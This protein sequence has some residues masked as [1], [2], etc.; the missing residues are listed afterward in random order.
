MAAGSERAVNAG[1]ASPSLPAAANFPGR[2]GRHPDS[3]C[4][5]A[6]LDSVPPDVGLLDRLGPARAVREGLLPWR[7]AGAVT[8]V[9]ATSPGA[10]EAGRARLEA[11][12]GPVALAS[13]TS[14]AVEAAVLAVRRGQLSARAEDRTPVRL[15]CRSLG[16]P[17][18]AV[19][20]TAAG[21]AVLAAAA[22]APALVFS[23]LV[24]W[25]SGWLLVSTLLRIAAAFAAGRTEPRRPP[26][27]PGRLPAISLL[28]PLFRERDIAG[29]LVAHLSRHDHP[30]SARSYRPAGDNAH[31]RRASR[32][33]ADEAPRAQLRPR[34]HAW[35]D[36][37]GL[38][39]RGLSGPRP[40]H[41]GRRPF[42]RRKARR[43]LPAR[44]ARLLQPAPELARALLHHRLRDVVRCHPARARPHGACRAPRR[45][46]A[47]F[48]PRRARPAGRVGRSQRHRGRRSRH[49]PRP[50]R[51]AHRTH[52]HRHGG[53]GQLPALALDQAALALDQGLCHDLGRPHEKAPDTSGRP[54]PLALLRLPGGVSGVPLPVH[55]RPPAVVVLAGASRP[56]APAR[57]CDAARTRSRARHALSRFGSRQHRRQRLGLPGCEAPL[58]HPLGT[59]DAFLFPARGHRL[60]EGAGGNRLASVLLGQDRPWHG[61]RT[62]RRVLSPALGVPLQPGLESL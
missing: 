20:L 56:A 21:L 5:P 11:L 17:G 47:L 3:A 6:S 1:P 28:V 52:P 32:Q 44:P 39:R 16:G 46:N 35:R 9:A 12:F 40:A 54:R 27:L 24:L 59:H 14:E 57:R 45:H 23:A 43:R 51:L 41:E 30:R 18:L 60:L 13:T 10:A 31:P 29:D 34:L 26:P 25:A 15:S 36:R 2:P 61:G 50:P 55:P 53:R 37:R 8:V 42:R 62:G 4:E 48:P 33:P 49:P 7:R 38:R 19:P 58:A 22:L